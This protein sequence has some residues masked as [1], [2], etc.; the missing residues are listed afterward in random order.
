MNIVNTATVYSPQIPKGIVREGPVFHAR[1]RR[2]KEV[3]RRTSRRVYELGLL[4]C[5]ESMF[6]IAGFST[7][8]AD[9]KVGGSAEALTPQRRFG[10]I[11]W[12]RE[13]FHTVFAEHARVAEATREICLAPLERAVDL[14][15][16]ALAAGNKILF[17]GNG[18]SA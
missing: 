8:R 16:E 14:V 12:V 6:A 17:F 15:T 7:D 10:T 3:L 2:R 1:S 11:L 9:P 5:G 13:R 18:G 4:R